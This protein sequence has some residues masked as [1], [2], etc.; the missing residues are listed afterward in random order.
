M[1]WTGDLARV[2]YLC[3]SGYWDKLQLGGLNMGGSEED[4][5]HGKTFSIRTLKCP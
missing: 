4:S 5:R 2:Y 1:R 3:T